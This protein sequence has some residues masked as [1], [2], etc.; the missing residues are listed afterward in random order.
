MHFIS[1]QVLP[2]IYGQKQRQIRDPRMEKPLYRLFRCK[3]R[4]SQILW[5]WKHMWGGYP[6]KMKNMRIS[7]TG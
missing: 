6:W 5:T 4:Q 1:K 2:S 3:I 7:K